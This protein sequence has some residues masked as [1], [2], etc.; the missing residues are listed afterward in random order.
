MFVHPRDAGP[1]RRVAV[2]GVLA[3]GALM[4]AMELRLGTVGEV[5]N[6]GQAG[7]LASAAKGLS[8][9]GAALLAKRGRKSRASAVLGGALVCAG[10]LCLRWSVFKAGFQSA[11]DPKYVVESQRGRIERDGTK[12]TKKPNG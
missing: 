11:R 6:Q 3:E 1:A 7:K 4:Q 8:V 2:A 10:E 5:Y 9:A 12:A